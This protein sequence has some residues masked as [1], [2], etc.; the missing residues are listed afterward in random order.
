MIALLDD[1]G[2]HGPAAETVERIETHGAIVFL[3]GDHALKLKKA[4]RFPYLDFSTPERRRAALERELELNRRTAAHLYVGVEAVTG[5]ADGTLALA[6]GGEPVDWILRMRRFDQD[7]LLDRVAARGG[8]TPGLMASLADRISA[9]HAVAPT[10]KEADGA[11]PLAAILGDIA[12]AFRSAGAVVAPETARRFEDR[13]R[14]ALE[15]NAARL[16]ARARSGYVRRCH[17]DLHLRNVALIDGRP[18]LFD[19]LE[20]DEA[21]ATIDVL[22]DLAF[23]LMDLW[24]RGLPAAANI[25]LN[26]YLWQSDDDQFDGLAALPLF[27]GLR[28]AIRARVALDRLGQSGGEAQ[29]A[30]AGEARHYVRTALS[31]LQPAAP[32]L[33]AIGG[34]SGTGKSTLGAALAPAF[35][36]PPGAVHLRTDTERKGLFGVD[37]ATRLDASNYTREA[38]EK[39]YRRVMEKA[40]RTL[41]A[42]HSVIV[43][44][45]FAR[46]GQ[47]AAIEA[48]ARNA[49]ASFVGLWLTAPEA[50][51]VERVEKR[52]G[53]A[54]DADAAV[55]RRQQQYELGAIGW[56]VVDAARPPGALRDAVATRLGLS[57]QSRS[58]S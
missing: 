57:P 5:E 47:R 49:G 28:A 13:A 12:A 32:R 30:G 27:L 26:R 15:R 56:A 16:D 38:T 8:L 2:T 52:E 31:L 50:I 9:F 18:T 33:L 55:V 34:L 25:V 21:L 40:E 11:A 7:A 58:R 35:G 10:H 53:D 23:L 39:V 48:V 51:L 20:F 54:S 46:P 22:Y 24:D 44:G 43:D 36:A 14:A 29:E 45:V 6:G 17:G 19:A 3:A 1:P 37:V 41:S 4:V 42:G